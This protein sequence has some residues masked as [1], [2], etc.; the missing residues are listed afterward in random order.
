MVFVILLSCETCQYG[1]KREK[2]TQKKL[3]HF[4]GVCYWFDVSKPCYQ[5]LEIKL[6]DKCRKF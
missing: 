5:S 3:F 4:S 2:K 6:K 1:H